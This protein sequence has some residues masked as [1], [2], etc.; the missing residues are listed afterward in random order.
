M[1][2]G[3]YAG[4]DALAHG[5][6]KLINI[7]G[8][9]G[10]GTA[11]AQSLGFLKA[12]EDAGK[13]IGGTA[14][15]VATDKTSGGADLEIVQ[16]ASGDWWADPA[17][18]AMADAITALGPDGWDGAYVQN[19][20]MMDGAIQAIEEAGL[21]PGDYWLG[22]SNGKEKSWKWVEDGKETM[23]VN[24]TPSL[25]G[26]LMYQVVLNYLKTGEPKYLVPSVIPYNTDNVTSLTLIP[27]EHTAYAEM[28]D[29]I[30][31][32]INSGEFEDATDLIT[33][34]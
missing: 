3:V 6:K 30:V 16:W 27:Y 19:D 12:Y 25:E 7:E 17:K 14:E 20:E 26:D 13:D 4:E 1:K 34:N 24:Q 31:T 22:S 28:K 2:C 33:W 5:V 15:E 10:Q 18:K 21:D 9:L 29:Q 23:D 32:D 11:S 8:K